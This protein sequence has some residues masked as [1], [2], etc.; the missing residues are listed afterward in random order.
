MKA[1]NYCNARLRETDKYCYN[2]GKSQKYETFPK[3]L[4]KQKE[5][6]KQAE[7]NF[8]NSNFNSLKS[9][10]EKE[11]EI[12]PTVLEYNLNHNTKLKI[13]VLELLEEASEMQDVYNKLIKI[14]YPILENQL[15]DLLQFRFQH[16]ALVKLIILL[17]KNNLLHRQTICGLT[18]IE[19][20][21][22][23]LNWGNLIKFPYT[24]EF[25]INERKIHLFYYNKHL[26]YSYNPNLLSKNNLEKIEQE[27]QEEKIGKIRDKNTL[28]KPIQELNQ[29]LSVIQKSEEQ[30]KNYNQNDIYYELISKTLISLYNKAFML[31]NSNKNRGIIHNQ[32]AKHYENIKNYKKA[33]QNYKYAQYF[34]KRSGSK[35]AY[36]KYR[37]KYGIEDE[38]TNK[39]FKYKL[40]ENIR[41]LQ[42]N[43]DELKKEKRQATKYKTPKGIKN[44]KQLIIDYYQEKG[45]HILSS[46]FI[47]YY[48]YLL[49][50][51]IHYDMEI[52][53]NT[54]YH[55]EEVITRIKELEKSNLKKE[56]KKAFKQIHQENTEDIETDKQIEEILLNLINVFGEEKILKIIGRNRLNQ[57]YDCRY[58]PCKGIPNFIVYN[59]DELFFTEIYTSNEKPNSRQMYWHYYISEKTG[60]PIELNLINKNKSDIEKIY[61]AK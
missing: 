30:L 20:I 19:W 21:N 41:I 9:I 44:K 8:N 17:D 59:N 43:A 11:T 39:E 42:H 37:K 25:T 5:L 3:T 53:V 4:E 23:D 12:L 52:T 51:D 57:I 13:K 33:Y 10:L 47:Y 60:I 50:L 22:K 29:F 36:E 15:Y 7:K 16:E 6:D 54:T 24:N 35:K 45:Y 46:E 28:E 55:K 1:C 14:D 61:L 48:T 26:K 38:I 2:C 49:F 18:F 31:T 34:N 56:I 27:K 32:Q 58:L 40:L